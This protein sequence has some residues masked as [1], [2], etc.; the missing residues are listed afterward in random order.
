MG[1]RHDRNKMLNKN[2]E[3]M[4]KDGKDVVEKMLNERRVLNSKELFVME[5]R[6]S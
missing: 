3:E 5:K 1:T 4:M 6:N 2:E